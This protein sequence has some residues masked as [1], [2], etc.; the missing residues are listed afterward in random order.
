MASEQLQWLPSEWVVL[1][2]PVVLDWLVPGL[3]VLVLLLLVTV[4]R[5]RLAAS[6]S[7]TL[8]R[9]EMISLDCRTRRIEVVR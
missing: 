4:V 8:T 2:P 9:A 6:R 5:A 1:I 3:L 7:A